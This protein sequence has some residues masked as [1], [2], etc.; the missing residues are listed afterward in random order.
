MEFIL[1]EIQLKCVLQ[2]VKGIMVANGVHWNLRKSHPFLK[3][4]PIGVFWEREQDQTLN[5]LSIDFL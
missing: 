5:D 2:Q 1:W 4:G 3:A